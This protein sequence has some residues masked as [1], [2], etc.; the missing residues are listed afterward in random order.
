MKRTIQI[1]AFFL[2]LFSY[3]LFIIY[4]MYILSGAKLGDDKDYPFMDP[5]LVIFTQ[6]FKNSLGDIAMPD[7]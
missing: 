4:T 5:R 1:L 6:V 2:I 3:F 7:Y